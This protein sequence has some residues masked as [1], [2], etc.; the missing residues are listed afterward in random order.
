MKNIIVAVCLT[1]LIIS[2]ISC[3]KTAVQTSSLA[4]KWNIINDSLSIISLS[5]T[6]YIGT[7]NDYYNFTVNGILYIKEDSLLSTTT[8]SMIANNQIDIV[9]DLSNNVMEHRT[10]YITNLTAHTATLTLSGSSPG[11][12]ERQIIN[13]KK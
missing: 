13:L 10:Y 4:A 2:I 3:N 6:N 7:S 9:Y 1:F 11:P 5:G 8:Y 12:A